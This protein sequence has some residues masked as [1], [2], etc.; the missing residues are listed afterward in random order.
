MKLRL[1]LLNG[2]CDLSI[3]AIGNDH[4]PVKSFASSRYGLHERGQQLDIPVGRLLGSDAAANDLFNAFK[5]A[6][7]P[8]QLKIVEVLER[9]AQLDISSLKDYYDDQP[10]T[11]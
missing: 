7:L 11:V 10:E 5:A 6:P 1:T 8:V 9:Y 4:R 2:R 3:S